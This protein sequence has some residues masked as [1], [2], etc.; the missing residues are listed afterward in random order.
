MSGKSGTRGVGFEI[1]LVLCEESVV[2]GLWSGATD[3]R[4]NRL[5]VGIV[6]GSNGDEA[7]CVIS[8]DSSGNRGLIQITHC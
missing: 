7:G 4:R 2:A 3:E 1:A 8:A 5:G 6:M